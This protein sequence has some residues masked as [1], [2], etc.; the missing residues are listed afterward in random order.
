[1]RALLAA[2]LAAGLAPAPALAEGGLTAAPFLR[3]PLSARGSA[4]GD[5]F[6]AVAGG[7]DSIGYNPAGL[8]GAARPTLQTSL[9]K[10]SVED[11]FG[12]AAY[13][14]PL[15]KATLAA[16]LMYYDAGDVHLTF[17]DGTRRTVKA[18]Q[19][20][21]AIGGLSLPLGGGLTVGGLAKAFQLNLAEQ[22]SATGF[23]AD[24]GALWNAPLEGLSLGGSLQNLGPDVT[25]ESA[26]DPLP[27]TARAGASYLLDLEKRGLSTD[28]PYTFTRFRFSGE[29]V[30]VREERVSAAV[31]L[32]MDIPFGPRGHGA[33]RF[34]YLFN[35]DI[36]SLTVGAGFRDKRFLLDYAVGLKEA[37]S[38]THLLTLGILF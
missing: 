31:G 32:E 18:A 1:M 17:S 4:L 29:G 35:R 7:L 33:L 26:G 22:A 20:F 9:M 24:A 21:G 34:G 37:L 5:A 19:D 13:A 28:I 6:A 8:S 3:F 25:F 12:F 38:N 27:M 2:A 30:K 11:T 36:D 15:G 23:A 10:G 16:G 14:H